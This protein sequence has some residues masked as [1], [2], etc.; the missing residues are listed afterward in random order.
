VS[1]DRS[2][3][4]VCGRPLIPGFSVNQ[5]HLIPKLKGGTEADPIHRVCHDKIHATWDE[6]RLRDEYNTWKSIREAPEM[7][8][9]IKWVRKKPDDFTSPSRMARGHKRRRRR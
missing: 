4:P 9:F 2:P 3:C 8:N 6:N 5:H 1:E 7:Q